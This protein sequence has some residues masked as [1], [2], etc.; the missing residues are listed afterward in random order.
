MNILAL[1]ASTSSAK[2]IIYSSTEGLI[3]AL[4]QPFHESISNIVTQD[5]E[6]VYRALLK[7]GKSLLDSS[8]ESMDGCIDAVALSSTWH[9][10]LLTD[11]AGNP[12]GRTLTWANNDS[13]ET[14]EAYKRNRSLVEDIYQRTGCPV[15]TNFPLWK[16]IHAKE[17]EGIERGTVL[18]SSQPQ[19]IF[20]R[21]TGERM[22]SRSVASG[23]GFMNIHT[24]E[25]DEEI[26]EFA[27][28]SPDQMAPLSEPEYVAP[29]TIEAAEYL[30]VKPH[31]PVVITGPDGA[32][33]QIGAGALGDGIMTMSVGTSGAIRMSTDNP[34]IPKKPSTWCYYTAEGKRLAGAATSGAGN[35]VNWFVKKLNRGEYS[36]GQLEAM[37]DQKD[38]SDAPIFLP[39]LYGERSPGW[40]G[41]RLGGFEG[42]RGHHDTVDMYYSILEGV[43]FNLYQCYEIL[44]GVGKP[45]VEIRISGGIE[46]SKLWLQMAAD[47]FEREIYTF[48]LEHA[49]IMGAVVIALKVLGEL[50]SLQDFELHSKNKIMPNH[51]KFGFYRQR[52]QRYIDWYSRTLD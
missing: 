9:S 25:W 18:L 44:S 42:I 47:I 4:D 6:G 15:H 49:S 46:N 34:I 10:I 51:K 21:L 23:S 52:Y 17:K 29:L 37:I 5:P 19:Y 27:G 1:E 45:P 20:Y 35:C 11:K 39:F 38:L 16:W 3:A 22:E 40:R 12:L 24:L 13:A 33:N 26:L 14:V 7:C 48:D 32:L 41:A 2:A 31:I 8:H 36:Y 30:N 43:L 28:V 50:N